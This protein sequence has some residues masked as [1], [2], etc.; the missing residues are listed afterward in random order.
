MQNEHTP[1]CSLV[2]FDRGC[3]ARPTQRHKEI[4]MIAPEDAIIASVDE[5]NEVRALASAV[6]AGRLDVAD[7]YALA[8][9]LEEEAK[10][11]CE[12]AREF[13]PV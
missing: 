1:R 2:S 7:M 8:E 13:L 4:P 6:R 5:E 10:S 3:T 12:A 11:I 9:E